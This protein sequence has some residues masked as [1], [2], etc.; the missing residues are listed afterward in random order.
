[1]KKM[2]SEYAPWSAL[3]APTSAAHVLVIGAGIAGAST[4]WALI[5][6]GFKVTLIEKAT[7]AGQQ[8]S[9][10][11]AGLMMPALATDQSSFAEYFIQAY[12]YSIGHA[13]TL[14]KSHDFNFSQTGIIQLA[15]NQRQQKRQQNWLQ[16]DHLTSLMDAVT[17]EE[18]K[19]LSGLDFNHQGVYFKEAAW[20]SPLLYV[21]AHL[22]DCKEQLQC[23]FSCDVKKLN[24]QQG[25]W[26]LYDQGDELIASA[27]LVVLANAADAMQLIDDLPLSLRTVRGQISMLQQNKSTCALKLPV[28]YDGYLTPSMGGK[29]WLGATFSDAISAEC[30]PEDRKLNMDQLANVLPGFSYSEEGQLNI[31]QD[32]AALRC[33]ATDY[34]PVVGPVPNVTFY[35][36]HYQRLIQD[37]RAYRYPTAEYLPGLYMNIAHGSRGMVSAPFAAELLV[38]EICGNTLNISSRLRDHLHP[39]RF[40]I[41]QLKKG[42]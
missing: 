30:S 28:C 6:Q 35:R 18:V 19:S 7:K 42:K 36:Q 21:Q 23:I 14:A 26:Q 25:Q 20:L 15:F 37:R 22:N 17:R 13:K 3:A 32:R 12:S 38:R 9:G 31:R 41:R 40:L 5:K 39:G 8:A 1:M 16:L 11:P 24:Y 2:M 34:L 10:N 33:I 4:S 29:Q 27:P